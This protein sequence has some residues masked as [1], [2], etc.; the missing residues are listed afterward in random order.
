MKQGH[1]YVCLAA[2]PKSPFFKL[3]TGPWKKLLLA[4]QF[5]RWAFWAAQSCRNSQCCNHTPYIQPELQPRPLS[6]WAP[7]RLCHWPT[8]NKSPYGPTPRF[9][10][11]SSWLSRHLGWHKLYL[12]LFMTQVRSL[13]EYKSYYYFCY[14]TWLFTLA[15]RLSSTSPGSTTTVR[16]CSDTSQK[17]GVKRILAILLSEDELEQT[18][19]HTRHHTE[20]HSL[21]WPC[22]N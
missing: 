21:T 2:W 20:S 16:L 1:K 13:K 9:A 17:S 6:S 8:I 5:Q 11:L 12:K 14:T 15:A 4:L 7:A 19:D 22:S 3:G 10:H 18:P